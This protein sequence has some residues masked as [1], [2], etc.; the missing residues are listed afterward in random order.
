MHIDD[1]DDDVETTIPQKYGKSMPFDKCLDKEHTMQQSDLY[2]EKQARR[3][4]IYRLFNGE[5]ICTVTTYLST[6]T[7]STSSQP[8]VTKT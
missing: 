5:L 8:F 1:D 3:G 4:N 6:R 7:R 2:I